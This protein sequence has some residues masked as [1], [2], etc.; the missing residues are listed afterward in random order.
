MSLA[1]TLLSKKRAVGNKITYQ[2]KGVLSN[3]YTNSGGVGNVG[4]PGETVNFDAATNPNLVARPKLPRGPAAKL[5][6]NTD[7]RVYLP[8][9][10][11]GQ[12]EQNANNPTAANY[13]L[14]LF[15]TAATEL[16]AGAYPAGLTAEPLVIEVDVPSKYI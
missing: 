8:N 2:Y 6:A 11:D 7:C 12:I 14:R 16:G 15:T 4:T 9:G 13:V 3:N 5:P 1:L 10:Y